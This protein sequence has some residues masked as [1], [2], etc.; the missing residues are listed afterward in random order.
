MK[1]SHDTDGSR[2]DADW[3]GSLASMEGLDSVEQQHDS[4]ALTLV[5]SAH[6]LYPGIVAAGTIAL[7]A[8]FL[9]QHYGGPVFLF[10]LL[11]GMAFHFL[12]Q[13]T[14]CIAGIDF[15]ARTV[16]RV[17][18][19]LLGVRITTSQ[20]VSLGL[21]PVLSVIA[22]VVTTT[23]IGIMLARRMGLG[24]NFG[25]LSGGAVAICGASAALA[26]SAALP[27]YERRNIETILTV[28]GVTTLS[29]IAMVLYPLF[30]TWLKLDMQQA[31]VFL[32]GTI[33]DVAQVVGAGYML[34][35]ETGDISTYVKLLRVAML[36]PVVLAIALLVTHASEPA[37]R[38]QFPLPLFL[39]GFVAL[40]A[41]NSIYPLPAA[42]VS[43]I[44]SISSWCLVAAISALGMKTSL[45]D[46]IKVGWQPVVLMFAETVWIALLVLG[47]VFLMR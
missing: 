8:T 25:L 1:P 19:A 45:G 12:H 28:V 26:I 42:I 47:M 11:L 27:H 32:G 4:R 37:T 5:Q 10:A 40:V 2:K 15:C 6:R 36:I 34:S 35:Q 14:R 24:K 3:L 18:V 7:A 29:T 13:E 22:G 46:L 38:R 30:V 43:N 44:T 9:S 17:G 31:G 21:I 39:V 20:I 16:L 41:L 23:F 33:H